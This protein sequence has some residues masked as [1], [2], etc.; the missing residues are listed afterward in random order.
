MFG[1]GPT[2]L[3]VILVIALLVLGPKRL[4]EIARALGRGLA[5][6]RRAT[7]DVTTEL[8]N[9]RVMLEE[10]ARRAAEKKPPARAK[11]PPERDEPKGE[12]EADSAA[13]PAPQEKDPAS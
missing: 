8:D 12:P 1:I 11:K 2:E 6:F 13:A 4:P 5:E 10:E 9:A 7:A 3:I